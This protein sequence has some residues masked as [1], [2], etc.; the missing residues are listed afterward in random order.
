MASSEAQKQ[1]F[2][3]AQ[4]AG[5]SNGAPGATSGAGSPP[6]FD[7]KLITVV[8][9]LLGA[10]PGHAVQVLQILPNI[11]QLANEQNMNSMNR[12]Q[13]KAVS[14]LLIYV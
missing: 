5:S 12:Q 14:C 2:Q 6:K 9:R 7:P 13:L 11:P 4:F 10:S 1:Q 8:A 3:V